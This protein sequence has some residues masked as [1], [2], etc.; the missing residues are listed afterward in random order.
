MIIEKNIRKMSCI[1]TQLFYICGN[2]TRFAYHKN[3]MRVILF[4]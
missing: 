2:S 4:L 3:C 1:V